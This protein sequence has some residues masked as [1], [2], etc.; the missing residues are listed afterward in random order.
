MGNAAVVAEPEAPRLIA[1]VSAPEEIDFGASLRLHDVVALA[2]VAD[3]GAHRERWLSGGLVLREGGSTCAVI[4]SAHEGI[5][6]RFVVAY[7]PPRGEILWSHSIASDDATAPLVFGAE[8]PTTIEHRG[9]V[10]SRK[11]RL[12][13]DVARIG[14]DAPRFATA[15]LFVEYAS[16]GRE[17]L[18]LLAA[19]GVVVEVFGQVLRR[20]EYDPMGNGAPR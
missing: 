4:F 6:P 2:S 14:K 3:V 10:F 11:R 18:V 19:E 20:E 1:A 12:H 16:S 7:A 5:T 8:P 15:G 17:A 13:V 9:T